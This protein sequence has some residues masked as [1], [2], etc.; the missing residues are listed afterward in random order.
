MIMALKEIQ[1]YVNLKEEKCLITKMTGKPNCAEMLVE[2]QKFV[3]M[4][5]GNFF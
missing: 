3:V 1:S 4:H 5:F 2:I